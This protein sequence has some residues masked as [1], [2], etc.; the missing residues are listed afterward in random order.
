MNLKT[1]RII[2]RRHLKHVM[3]LAI[4]LV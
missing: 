4:A 2:G 3:K 1:T